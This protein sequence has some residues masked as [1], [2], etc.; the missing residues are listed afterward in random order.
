MIGGEPSYEA[1]VAQVVG[2]VEAPY[3]SVNLS[4]DARGTAFQ[5]PVWLSLRAPPGQQPATPKLPKDWYVKVRPGS[6]LGLRGEYAGDRYSLP[7]R[8]LHRGRPVRKLG[9]MLRTR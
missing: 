9:S 6:N 2:P 5:Q 8:R 1:P 4:L 7:S 3:V